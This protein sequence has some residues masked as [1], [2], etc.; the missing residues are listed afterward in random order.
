M[1]ATVFQGVVIP[2]KSFKLI[3]HIL[4]NSSLESCLP[5]PPHYTYRARG[6]YNEFTS[7]ISVSIL[8]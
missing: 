2:E 4:A 7:R 1:V 6:C 8:L 5:L 3:I